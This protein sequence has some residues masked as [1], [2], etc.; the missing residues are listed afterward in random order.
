M[1]WSTARRT[2]EWI[3]TIIATYTLSTLT[4]LNT[5]LANIHSIGVIRRVR[6]QTSVL[7][8]LFD[9][10]AVSCGITLLTTPSIASTS[11]HPKEGAHCLLIKDRDS[12]RD[13]ICPFGIH[14]ATSE[15]NAH[16]M[17]ACVR[18]NQRIEVAENAQGVIDPTTLTAKTRQSNSWAK[19]SW[20]V[21][22]I[23]YT[24][25]IMVVSSD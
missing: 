3:M 19:L 7:V 23:L 24:D 5:R 15:P 10:D 22:K 12:H 11:G 17:E 16:G 13:Y 21:N 8:V 18:A 14:V 4:P 2:G 6:N 20:G 1:A 25:V 9:A